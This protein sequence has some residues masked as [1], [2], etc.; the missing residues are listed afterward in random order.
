MLGSSWSWLQC[1][2]CLIKSTVI[3]KTQNQIQTE[4][5]EDVLGFHI[6]FASLFHQVPSIN[7]GCRLL[8][9]GLLRGHL[10]NLPPC[11]WDTVISMSLPLL[12]K[13]ERSTG[14]SQD[15][16]SFFLR[17]MNVSGQP[18][19]WDHWKAPWDKHGWDWGCY[20]FSKA[21]HKAREKS[22]S[23]LLQETHLGWMSRTK[24][25]RCCFNSIDI[26]LK[27]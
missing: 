9:L 2:L 19:S 17:V 6:G 27:E 10:R 8:E 3:N 14:S 26:Q 13:A 4:I 11:F 22:F 24:N 20:I 7:L 5:H 18:E 21:V 1:K 15:S 16:L 23:P 25:G 12:L